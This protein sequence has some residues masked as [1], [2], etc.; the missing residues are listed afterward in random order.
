MSGKRAIGE[1]MASLRIEAQIELRPRILRC[2]GRL[3]S[4]NESVA[5]SGRVLSFEIASRRFVSPRMSGIVNPGFMAANLL[6]SCSR[7]QT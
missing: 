1:K 3:D 2:A 4:L 7:S 6:R 5:S